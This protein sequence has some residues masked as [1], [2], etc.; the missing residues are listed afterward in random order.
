MANQDGSVIIKVD[1][2]LDDFNKTEKESEK[3]ASNL[4]K[5]FSK[6]GTSVANGIKTAFDVTLKAIAATSAAVIAVSAIGINYNMQMENY[7]ADFTVMLESTEAAVDHVEKLKDMAAKTPF[8]MTDLAQADKILLAFGS[9]ADTV[10]EQ[11]QM[12]GDISLGN[13]EKLNTIATAFG[14]IQSNGR[15]SMEELN[16]MI[17]AGFN[18][19]N[20]I[21]RETG[22]TMEEVRKRVSD[23]GVS[24][25]EIAEAM[26]KATSA[27]G[28]FYKGMEVASKTA[29][30]QISTLQDNIN[31]LLGD[32]TEGLFEGLKND[33]IPRVNDAVEQIHTAFN[34]GGTEAAFE[35]AADIL[36]GFIGEIAA[37]APGA[38]SGMVKTILPKI[39]ETGRTI[40]LALVEAMLG[41]DIA[42]QL[43]ELFD[44]MDDAFGELV[45]VIADNADDITG[46][47]SDIISII[48]EIAE[49]AL[50]LFIDGVS[51]LLDHLEDLAP[52]L[53]GVAAGFAAIKAVSAVQGIITGITGAFTA[54]NTVLLANPI[55]ATVGLL[56]GA[57]VTLY[58]VLS[59]DGDFIKDTAGD[60]MELSKAE[61][62][63]LDRTNEYVDAWE[64][65]K[66]ISEEKSNAATSEYGYYQ[67]LS[68]ELKTIV[69]NEG[70]IMRGYEERANFITTTLSD[71][72]GVEIE[73]IDGQ[74]QGYKDL[75]AEIDNTI[76]K[77]L[78]EAQLDAYRDQ[79]NEALAKE[80]QLR[81]DYVTIADAVRK[82]E[83]KLNELREDIAKH[84]EQ[85]NAGVEDTMWF[86]EKW[87]FNTINAVDVQKE[88]EK[89]LEDL[90]GSLGEA[91]TALFENKATLELYGEAM[92]AL[93][94]GEMENFKDAMLM[95]TE[96]MLTA[97]TANK[98]SLQ[99][100]VQEQSALLEQM[101]QAMKD[102]S[103]AITQA[104]IDE[105]KR[106]L[107]LSVAEYNKAANAAVN[108]GKYVA[109]SYAAG[110][111]DGQAP[112]SESVGY[113]NQ[114]ASNKAGVNLSSKGKA[115]GNS[116]AD[117][118][119]S[120]EGN[121]EE[122]SEKLADVVKEET[123]IS[124]KTAG[125][126]A[127]K[128]LAK[129]LEAAKDA[130]KKAAQSLKNVITGTVGGYDYT[131]SN[132]TGPGSESAYAINYTAVD[133]PH[134][135]K[136]AVIPPA[137]PFLAVL[138]D[139]SR[140]VGTNIEAPL[141]TIKQ[142]VAEVIGQGGGSREVHVHLNLSGRQIYEVIV[143]ENE[144]NTIATGV[145]ALA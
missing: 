100:Q 60:L 105:Q 108:G 132:P 13:S 103:L 134:L 63:A 145:N 52:I 38:L 65:L 111:K 27:G 71:A 21:A 95:M 50:P 85:V 139:Q 59:D 73:I 18:P 124:L 137:A 142:A 4:T 93:E 90:S 26:K 51:W 118:I 48:L 74:I 44:S 123:D 20:I 75:Q 28:Q 76:Q 121:V 35:T 117:G 15:A 78:G 5:N 88:F 9:T 83:Q 97:E 55:V 91:E 138:G 77:K 7:L 70:V 128:T 101:E 126:D 144:S 94:S 84:Q 54:L 39:K 104:E 12:L 24:Y 106:R 53:L 130:V 36:K 29:S 89:E 98:E 10:Q 127:G 34:E 6:A 133:I 87:G 129:G 110:I 61:Q 96:S 42:D 45:E 69:D 56:A 102:G 17:D 120:T 107:E 32:L 113:L 22:E 49:F 30:G 81:K 47:I 109:T 80:N 82:K 143:D 58:T 16:M 136:G 115:T 19:L 135:A 62:E 3:L 131:Y 114:T 2:N 1:L 37:K 14:R 33:L 140:S 72:L 112:V 125:K 122:S 68:D 64:E 57:F 46:A 119:S 86:Y 41:N 31:A 79:Y 67:R 116:Y 66:T 43:S 40:I 25:E 99:R 11:L 141:D 23:G 92:A 8:E